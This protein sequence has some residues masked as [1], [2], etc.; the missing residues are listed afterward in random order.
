VQACY[1]ECLTDRFVGLPDEK[2]VAVAGGRD[3]E[4]LLGGG[5]AEG[6]A[7]V[8]FGVGELEQG[9]FEHRTG[10]E[11]GDVAKQQDDHFLMFA[12]AALGNVDLSDG[13]ESHGG[14]G[15]FFMVASYCHRSTL[16]RRLNVIRTLPRADGLNSGK[17][18]KLTRS[19]AFEM[20]LKLDE[21]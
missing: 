21:G 11:L 19:E 7:D 17:A 20:S 2:E 5:A 13:V 12:V 4:L 9:D 14:E 16:N 1:S 3:G 6:G 10:A 18:L 8:F 15:Y